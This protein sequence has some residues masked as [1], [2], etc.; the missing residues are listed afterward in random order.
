MG[1]IQEDTTAL[2]KNVQIW[3]VLLI[4]SARTARRDAKL[5][6]G[7]RELFTN[8]SVGRNEEGFLRGTRWAIALTRA[9]SVL[10]LLVL[11]HVLQFD[12]ARLG[13]MR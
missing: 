11:K 13:R 9:A 6:E 2:K 3:G 10:L 1:F 12:H 4:R 7:G 5:G 8:L